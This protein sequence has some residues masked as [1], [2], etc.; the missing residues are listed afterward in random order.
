M[1]KFVLNA[2]LQLQAPKNVAQVVN[3]IKSQLRGGVDLEINA[4]GAA[5]AQ[6]EI[7]KIRSETDKAAGSAGRMN[8]AF[9]VSARRFGALAIATRTVSVFTNTLSSAIK[10]AISFERELVKISQVTGK[11]MKDLRGLTSTITDLSRTFGVA[12]SSLLGI[13]RILSQA[14]FNAKQTEIA[15]G[16][17]ARTELAPTFENITQTAEGAVAIFNQFRL[18]AEALESQ[19][20]SINAV[21]G[22]FAVEAGDL[23][24]V[25]RRTG[26]VF[27]SAGGDLN[28][29]VAL[30]T[31]VRSTTRE[32][33]ESIATGLRT[34][35]TRIQ[36]PRTIEFLKQFGVN[37]L[38]L[39]GKF[40]GPFEAVQ[41]LGAALGGLEQ[42]DIT[43]VKIAEELGGFRQIGKV[44]PL[45]QQTRVAQEALNVAQGGSASL[46]SDAAKAQLTL[47]VR[48]EK[49]QQEFIA[50]IRSVS[51]TRSFQLMANTAIALAEGIVKVGE[52]IKPVLPLLSAL[53]AFKLVK[54]FGGLS[55]SIAKQ[56]SQLKPQGFASGGVV[57]GHGNRDTVPAMLTPG[58]FVIKKSS[59]AKLGASNLASM[60]QYASGGIVEQLK[61]KNVTVGAAI[62]DPN[63]PSSQAGSFSI[64]GQEVNKGAPDAKI[65]TGKM[66]DTAEL[67]GGSRMSS[68]R[69]NAIRKGLRPK[70]SKEFNSALDVGLTEAVNNTLRVMGEKLGLKTKAIQKSEQKQFL[71]GVNSASRGNLFE[72]VLLALRGGPFDARKPGQDFD[73]PNG[74]PGVLSDDYKGLPKSLVDAKASYETA[75]IAGAKSGSLKSKTM[76]HMIKTI[77]SFGDQY[78]MR[79]QGAEDEE[80]KS[81]KKQ[82]PV[83]G[84]AYRMYDIKRFGFKTAKSALASGRFEATGVNGQYKALNAGGPAGFGTDTVPA[85]LTPG[86]FVV[87][88]KSAQ[89]IGYGNLRRMNKVGKYANGGVVQHFQG[90]DKVHPVEGDAGFIGPV[91]T[92]EMKTAALEKAQAKL[93]ARFAAAGASAFVLSSAL[94]S[95]LPAVT[96]NEGATLRLTR[97]L[98]DGVTSTV[99][100][101]GTL[102]F[103][104]SSLGK[105]FEIG[106]LMKNKFAGPLIAAGG[107]AMFVTTAFEAVFDS[108]N[109]F[110][111]AVKDQDTQLA[112]QLATQASTASARQGVAGA[113]GF[114]AGGLAGAGAAALST[115]PVGIFIAAAGAAALAAGVLT[116]GLKETADR[117]QDFLS[118]FGYAT[119]NTVKLNAEATIVTAR[120]NTALQK[121]SERAESAF[122]DAQTS[123][124]FAGTADRVFGSTVDL[125]SERRRVDKGRLAEQ[126]TNIEERY[127]PIAQRRT[128]AEGR[129]VKPTGMR[130]MLGFTDYTADLEFNENLPEIREKFIRFFEDSGNLVG[131]VDDVKKNLF[132]QFPDIEKAEEGWFSSLDLNSLISNYKEQAA[133]ADKTIASSQKFIN[134][135]FRELAMSGFS[136]ADLTGVAESERGAKLAG[137]FT[138][139]I[140]NLA[141][142]LGESLTKLFK[143]GLNDSQ[144]EELGR[145][146]QNIA[147]EV[148]RLRERFKL[149]NFGLDSF[150][151]NTKAGSLALSNYT[152]MVSGKSTELE[153]SLSVL[154]LALSSAGTAVS[155]NNFNQSLNTVEKALIQFGATGGSIADSRKKLTAGFTAQKA[156]GK[157]VEGLD[158]NDYTNLKSVGSLQQAITDIG[159]GLDKELQKAGVPETLRRSIVEDFRKTKPS[160]AL[161]T[162]FA[163][164]NMS[165]FKDTIESTNKAFLQQIE[166]VNQ[167]IAI[168]KELNT[169]KK[170]EAEAIQDSISAQRSSLAIQLEAAEIQAKFGGEVVTTK[171]R[172]RNLADSI[173]AGNRNTDL[174]NR[175]A[176]AGGLQRRGNEI[177]SKIQALESQRSGGTLDREGTNRLNALN[178]A[179]KENVSQT[180]ALISIKQ[181]EYDIVKKKIE[182]ERSAADALLEGDIDKFFKAQAAQGA[183]QSIAAGDA[184]TASS[185]GAGALAD[186]AQQLRSLRDAGES[187][188]N[189]QKIGGPG[190]LLERTLTL[191]FQRRGNDPN[192]ARIL[193]QQSAG[194]TP[195]LMA[196]GKELRLAAAALKA[197][198]KL[199]QQVAELKVETAKNVYI[200]AEKLSNPAAGASAAQAPR[201]NML[202]TVGSAALN[203]ISPTAGAA[204]S[205]AQNVDF[206]KVFEKFDESINKLQN[207][208]VEMKIS[209]PTVQVNLLNGQFLANLTS[210]LKGDI[211]G[212]IASEMQKMSLNNVGDFN[213]DGKVLS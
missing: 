151:S 203:F 186:A 52:A 110:N 9:A 55:G 185:F 105:N 135:G 54:G 103:A 134:Q 14:G 75:S 200:N 145:S 29:L 44:I 91:R 7:S 136:A 66:L 97:A 27:K 90:G 63:R 121:A 120:F 206:S 98:N 111:R 179:A 108:V 64:S 128:F 50:L 184:A 86:E 147:T 31:S 195:E 197:S 143:S 194:T 107:S 34:I 15:L 117:F 59:V 37:L 45:L 127:V 176:S 30:F 191:A 173:N 125:L 74:I 198:G 142:V 1:A 100:S 102:G 49:V 133:F 205:A 70:T 123:G 178:K 167:V 193:A 192:S 169:L 6:R 144:R 109:S 101:L 8:N 182:L 137:R 32:S 93:S 207:T 168:E 116:I 84:E 124:N 71:S 53:A 22:K 119:A 39:E 140:D 81:K 208:A 36:R 12:S 92:P 5:A 201:S 99:G 69:F 126:S 160:E 4:K 161:Q 2:Q 196:A 148:E 48:I 170:K 58:E 24:S 188:F 149:I 42:G 73:F 174:R 177:L 153:R 212:M 211:M 88:K 46:A 26:G 172:L 89:S 51:E 80:T 3:Q 159:D 180:R 132:R 83:S 62:L 61:K 156:I 112:R 154:T 94:N 16:T 68:V 85:M 118:N 104:L 209:L 21:A 87:N 43:F 155:D 25:I 171:D 150:D 72:D 38:D 130:A 199:Q 95:M 152:S 129:S 78:L 213:F 41:R 113:G 187:D 189:G 67:L 35:F 18:G 163:S 19:L 106:S 138:G 181:K 65:P 79:R 13:S 141:P 20:G 202:S 10:E 139:Q 60:N 164:G 57:P 166:N 122:K 82:G 157:I 28:E 17:L 131:D 204:L 162:A 11:S 76:R 183:L 210:Q 56:A 33:A 115:G 23:I 40:V 175:Q 47:A 190:G 96:E 77:L 158:P 165:K 114:V 146:L